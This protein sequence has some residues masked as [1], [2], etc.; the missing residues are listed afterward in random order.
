MSRVFCKGKDNSGSFVTRGSVASGEQFS[1]E[2]LSR[3]RLIRH[4]RIGAR[5]YT[6]KVS[7]DR[8]TKRLATAILTRALRDVLSGRELGLQQ[9]AGGWRKDALRW[10]RSN[11]EYPGSL[12][13]VSGIIGVD[14]EGIRQWVR[15]HAFGSETDR[16]KWRRKLGRTRSQR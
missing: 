4:L 15:E 6:R 5:F 9:A 12:M 3:K 11:E 14:V 2:S 13:W 10:F 16:R 1:S 8:S 7:V